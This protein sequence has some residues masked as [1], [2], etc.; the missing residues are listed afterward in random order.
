MLLLG[1][2]GRGLD[3]VACCNVATPVSLQCGE[4]T[5]GFN[6]CHSCLCGDGESDDDGVFSLSIQIS[7]WVSIQVRITM[8]LRFSTKEIQEFSDLSINYDDEE[9]YLWIVRTGRWPSN[10]RLLPITNLPLSQAQAQALSG[11]P[12]PFLTGFRSTSV[13]LDPSR[14]RLKSVE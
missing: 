10:C 5:R 12:F 1:P 2:S 6:G 13:L 3:F 8:I 14:S 4:C 9:P 11:L 7:L